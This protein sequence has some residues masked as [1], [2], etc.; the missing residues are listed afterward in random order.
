MTIYSITFQIVTILSC[1]GYSCLSRFDI[2]EHRHARVQLNLL[3]RTVY[4][5][6]IMSKVEL[7]YELEKVK[8]KL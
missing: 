6:M 3:Y 1:T 7:Q 5:A 8:N 2:L 4:K